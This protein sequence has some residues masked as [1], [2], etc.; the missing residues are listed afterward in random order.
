MNKEDKKQTETARECGL[1]PGTLK[2]QAFAL[3]DDGY[4]PI[5]VRFLL[6]RLPLEEAVQPG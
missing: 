6:C 2:C 1:N 4:S 5:E 3:F